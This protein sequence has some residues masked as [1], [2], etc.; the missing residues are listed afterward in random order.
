MLLLS[1]SIWPVC[2]QDTSG[3]SEWD[4][5][6][7]AV[8]RLSPDKFT[9]LPARIRKDLERLQCTIPQAFTES[10]RHNVISGSF[11]R[12]GQKDWAVLCSS[13]GVS[14]II[15]YWGGS[16]SKTSRVSSAADRGYLQGIGDGKIGYSRYID[17]V[18]RKYIAEHYKTYGGAKPPPIDHDGINVAFV[19]KASTVLYYYKGEWLALTGAD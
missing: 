16:I 13:G 15:I 2:G 5:A 11:L 3:D 4:A 19:E 6:D 18:G 8:V 10:V 9:E 17:V 1:L 12:K 7:A 14:S